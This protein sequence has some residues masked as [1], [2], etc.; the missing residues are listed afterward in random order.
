MN[1]PHAPPKLRELANGM[2]KVRDDI[3]GMGQRCP[4]KGKITIAYVGRLTNGKVFDQSRNFS[5]RIGAGEVIK[6]FD[7]GIGGSMPMKVGG[8]RQLIIAPP[9]A[10][11]KEGAK[12]SIPPNATLVFTVELLKVQ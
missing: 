10:Y 8:K 7:L 3:E 9:Y 12:P 11:G 1:S 5:F 4:S 2:I 6:G